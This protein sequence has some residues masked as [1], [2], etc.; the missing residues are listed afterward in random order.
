MKKCPYCAEEIQD[1]A[2]FCR[3]CRRDLVK[4]DNSRQKINANQ[5]CKAIYPDWPR[6]KILKDNLTRDDVASLVSNLTDAV[7]ASYEKLSK[8]LFLDMNVRLKIISDKY[9]VPLLTECFRNKLF[10]SNKYEKI[11]EQMFTWWNCESM[12][13]LISVLPSVGAEKEYG[14]ISNIEA[15]VRVVS[16]VNFLLAYVTAFRLMQRMVQDR[17]INPSWAQQFTRGILAEMNELASYAIK[18]GRIHYREFGR[19]CEP[20]SESPITIEF[21][22]LYQFMNNN[23]DGW[24]ERN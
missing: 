7:E 23:F 3:Y 12:L 17:R 15:E 5:P 18:Q 22:D 16:S 21:E 20:S 14:F 2:I 11:G 24:L 9:W 19:K 4:T 1:E 8:E 13:L 10:Q 6:K